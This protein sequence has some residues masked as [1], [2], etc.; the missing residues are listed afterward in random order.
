[1]GKSL[2]S[3]E[4]LD[5]ILRNLAGKYL[6]QQVIGLL[7]KIWRLTEEIFNNPEHNSKTRNEGKTNFLSVKILLEQD[8]RVR[9]F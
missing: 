8:K 3:N 1:M 6:S 2:I 7:Q 4:P 5:R 9:N